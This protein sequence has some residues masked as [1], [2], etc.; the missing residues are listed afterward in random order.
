MERYCSTGQSPQR[1][2]APME[3]EDR[4]LGQHL[5]ISYGRLFMITFLTFSSFRSFVRNSNDTTHFP[6]PKP[7]HHH[8]GSFFSVL[9]S[10]FISCAHY[11]PAYSI[12]H[13]VACRKLSRQTSYTH[14]YI[15]NWQKIQ[16]IKEMTHRPTL[17]CTSTPNKNVALLI[18]VRHSDIL[19]AT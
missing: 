9:S 6:N 16:K 5:Q 14:F 2:V 4:I 3:E 8:S 12:Y 1:A 19:S 15:T 10:G 17:S 18:A 7:Q 11:L 13:A